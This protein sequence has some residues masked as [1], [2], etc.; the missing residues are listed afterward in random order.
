MTLLSITRY[1]YLVILLISP[2]HVTLLCTYSPLCILTSCVYLLPTYYL[3]LLTCLL[4]HYF[5]IYIYSL[6]LHLPISA[7]YPVLI[8]MYSSKIWL[9]QTCE[10][11]GDCNLIGGFKEYGSKYEVTVVGVKKEIG[12]NFH[13]CRVR[14]FTLKISMIFNFSSSLSDYSKTFL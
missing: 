3:P 14:T 11:L 7:L 1:T 13:C 6:H 5:Q 4:T 8:F 2:G 9:L 12:L 10:I